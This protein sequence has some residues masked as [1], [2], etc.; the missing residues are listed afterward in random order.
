MKMSAF[1]RCL[2]GLQA[3]VTDSQPTPEGKYTSVYLYLILY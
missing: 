3:N 2:D 1:S